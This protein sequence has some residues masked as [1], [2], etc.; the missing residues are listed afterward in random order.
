MRITNADID[1]LIDTAQILK[2][3]ADMNVLPTEKLKFKTL[4][5][6]V[7]KTYIL[8]LKASGREI[9]DL[10]QMVFDGIIDDHELDAAITTLCP[11]AIP[12]D[13]KE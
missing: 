6:H 5:H 4:C 13:C 11:A 3:M 1:A 9:I 8:F 7:R 10:R 2:N 12:P